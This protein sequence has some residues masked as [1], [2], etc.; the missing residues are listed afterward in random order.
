[1]L[2]SPWSK[3]NHISNSFRKLSYDL[4]LFSSVNNGRHNLL[5]QNQNR[6]TNKSKKYQKLIPPNRIDVSFKSHTILALRASSFQVWSE[7]RIAVCWMDD[8]EDIRSD[9]RLEGGCERIKEDGWSDFWNWGGDIGRTQ[10]MKFWWMWST[11]ARG[12]QGMKRGGPMV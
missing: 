12:W 9:G 2:T 6:P 1:M 7:M 11:G 8:S 3:R 4:I 5:K 10:M